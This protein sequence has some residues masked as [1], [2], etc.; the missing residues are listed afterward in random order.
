MCECVNNVFKLNLAELSKSDS[1]EQEKPQDNSNEEKD[2]KDKI[3]SNINSNIKLDENE[4][5]NE[6]N[7]N[8][9]S[10]TKTP[11]GKANKVKKH[12]RK[13][14]LK[15]YPDENNSPQHPKKIYTEEE[16]IS[17]ALELS[18]NYNSLLVSKRNN[19]NILFLKRK[20]EQNFER[21][22]KLKIFFNAPFFPKEEMFP[23]CRGHNPQNM[24]NMNRN[25]QYTA[26][27]R[28][29]IVPNRN[30]NQ[31]MNTK[32]PVNNNINNYRQ[33]SIINLGVNNNNKTNNINL[34]NQANRPPPN[35]SQ[36]K[37]PVNNI[38]LNNKTV[39]DTSIINEN[40]N[41]FASGIKND[42][43]NSNKKNFLFSLKSQNDNNQNENKEIDLNKKVD[44]GKESIKKEEN[45]KKE[46]ASGMSNV[47][48]EVKINCNI[49]L[50]PNERRIDLGVKKPPKEKSDKE[51]SDKK[52]DSSKKL[53]D[54]IK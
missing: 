39:L 38:S 4:E 8:E 15:I 43:N 5:I 20:I 7:N 51:K 54:I 27:I 35:K 10:N 34:N 42:I 45:I 44:I 36:P 32:Y 48:I 53:G 13:S 14:R 11:Q 40:N 16:K 50:A 47:E 25:A 37:N 33:N 52:I 26:Q 46:N 49:N 23:S 12:N 17:K 3:N 6:F 22:D 9:N 24:M 18:N 31:Q 29:G 1:P 19:L 30:I 28:N 2:N 41:N 21:E